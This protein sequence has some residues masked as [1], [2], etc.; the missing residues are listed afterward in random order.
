MTMVTSSPAVTVLRAEDYDRAKAFYTDKLGL[1]LEREDDTGGKQGVFAAGSGTKILV[2]E[3]PG[4]PAPQNTAFGFTVDDIDA[5]VSELRAT[6]VEFEDYDM[7]E[8][9]LVTQDGIATLGDTK[10]AWFTD[11]EGN[12]GMLGNT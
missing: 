8:L 4:M 7:P 2:Y 9:G 5:A 6:G 12:I 1:R 11:S 10:V 3:R